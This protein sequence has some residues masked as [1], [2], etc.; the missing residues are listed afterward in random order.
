M[1]ETPVNRAR[2]RAL[3]SKAT[4]GPWESTGSRYG[5]I[6]IFGPNREMVADKH[7]DAPDVVRLRGTGAGLPQAGLP[8][9][10]NAAYIAAVSPDVVL[11]LLDELERVERERD[12]AKASY[13]F[14]VDKV[15]NNSLEHYR[16]MGREVVAQIERA[17]RA[18]AKNAALQERIAFLETWPRRVMDYVC[19]CGDEFP[20]LE[21]FAAHH[22]MMHPERI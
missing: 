6:Y 10:C 4:T 11:T 3:A 15:A 5:C 7:D 13:Q 19:A 9:E 12:A 20:S 17:E 18:E 8:Q 16:E 22:Q 1:S 2:L 21:E 14:M